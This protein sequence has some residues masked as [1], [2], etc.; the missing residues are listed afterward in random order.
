MKAESDMA[1]KWFALKAEEAMEE[2][3]KKRS[4][5]GNYKECCACGSPN[6]PK[7]LDLD[8]ESSP[9]LISSGASAPSSVDAEDKGEK[10]ESDDESCNNTLSSLLGIV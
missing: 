2:F 1:K 10:E 6:T 5:T 8:A 7:R 9:V 4:K 3:T